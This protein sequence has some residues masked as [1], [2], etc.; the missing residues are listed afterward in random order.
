M[1]QYTEQIISYTTTN[2]VEQNIRNRNAELNKVRPEGYRYISA[3]LVSSLAQSDNTRIDTE[4]ISYESV[5][6]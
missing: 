3:H 4:V 1:K 5:Q 6:K 2:K